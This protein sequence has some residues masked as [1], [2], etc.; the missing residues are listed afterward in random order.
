VNNIARDY[1]RV[2]PTIRDA[3]LGHVGSSVLSHYEG[4]LPAQRDEAIDQIRTA[5]VA[6]LTDPRM[7]QGKVL[8]VIPGGLLSR[9]RAKTSA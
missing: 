5:I 6:L 3:L 8:Q 9:W 2:D 1:A 7:P 4:V